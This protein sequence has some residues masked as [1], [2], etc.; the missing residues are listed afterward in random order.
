MRKD[1]IAKIVSLIV[2]LAI[3][4]CL[5]IY[6]VYRQKWAYIVVSISTVLLIILANIRSFV[7]NKQRKKKNDK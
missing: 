5:I 2:I 3:L 1:S 4:V 7:S 6:L